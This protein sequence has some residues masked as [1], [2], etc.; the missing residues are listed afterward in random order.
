MAHDNDD[1][2]E[3]VASDTAFPISNLIFNQQALGQRERLHLKF[4]S[5]KRVANIQILTDH[6]NIVESND[7]E[8]IEDLD[9]SPTQIMLDK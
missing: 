9:G 4:S 1:K 3:N 8:S 2:I 6:S 5:S 7:E